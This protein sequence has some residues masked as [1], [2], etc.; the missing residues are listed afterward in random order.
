MTLHIK[1][2]SENLKRKDHLVDPS[3]DV[4]IILKRT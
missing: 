2:E 1:T 4:R 3:V